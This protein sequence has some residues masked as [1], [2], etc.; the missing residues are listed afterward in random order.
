MH[1]KNSGKYFLVLNP[2]KNNS[3]NIKHR[4]PFAAADFLQVIIDQNYAY[5]QN[6]NNEIW[7]Y[8]YSSGNKEKVGYFTNLMNYWGQGFNVSNDDKEL[9]Y[10][11]HKRSAKLVLIEGLFLK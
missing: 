6:I 5:M 8:N 1:Y 4:N 10:L 7:K 3:F 11:E 9:V 2:D